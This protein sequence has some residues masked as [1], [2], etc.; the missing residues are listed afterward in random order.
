MNKENFD[1]YAELKI[2]A[3]KIDAELE[4]LKDKIIADMRDAEADKVD[5]QLGT[6]NRSVHTKY[7]FSD[8][9]EADRQRIKD[10]EKDEKA[11]GTA[12][13]EESPKLIFVEKKI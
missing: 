11:D 10:R 4:E 2:E 3:K 13:V 5:H 12:K 7:T 8:A 9:L 6:F 1:R